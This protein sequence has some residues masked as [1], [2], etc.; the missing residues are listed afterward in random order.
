[1]PD[2]IEGI[3]YAFKGIV[4]IFFRWGCMGNLS[5]V[6]VLHTVDDRWHTSSLER[7]AGVR[8]GSSAFNAVRG[9]QQQNGF[10]CC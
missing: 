5:T 6:S 1:M 9:R 7:R 10:F 3:A 4:Q 8:H 2:G